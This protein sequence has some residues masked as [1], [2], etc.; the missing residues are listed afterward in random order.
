VGE[1]VRAFGLIIFQSEIGRTFYCNDIVPKGYELFW[2][3]K[4]QLWAIKKN[5]KYIIKYEDDYWLISDNPENTTF[6]DSCHAK[7]YLAKA[8]KY[9]TKKEISE[10]IWT[11]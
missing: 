8:V 1:Y 6:D 4:A 7:E 11:K 2:N 10:S 9:Y 5:G 3:D